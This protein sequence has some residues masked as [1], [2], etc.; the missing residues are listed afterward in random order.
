MDTKPRFI[1]FLVIATAVASALLIAVGAVFEASSPPKAN[2]LLAEGRPRIGRVEAKIELVLIEDMRCGACHFFTEKIFPDIYQRYIETGKA[3]CILVP[4]AFLDGSEPLG[5]AILAVYKL[6]PERFLPYLHAVFNHF[7]GRESNGFEVRELLNLAESVGGIDLMR[8][9]EYILS[10]RFS[11]Q[12]KQNIEWAK[13]F[14]G[15][16]FGTPTLYVNG[17]RTSVSS[18]DPIA[19]RIEKLDKE[20]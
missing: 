3:Y 10:N 7:K 17:I 20:Q 1:H 8:L 19:A 13:R 9:R 14:M 4:V 5:N 15:R 6:A 2:E 12:L 16:G 11:N 18:Y